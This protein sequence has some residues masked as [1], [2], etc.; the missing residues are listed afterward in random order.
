MLKKITKQQWVLISGDVIIA[1]IIT[2]W[3]FASH[4][5]LDTAGLYMLTTF[6]PVLVAW[7]MIAPLLGVYDLDRMKNIRQFW[8]PFYAM[9]IVSPMAALIRAFWLGRGIAPLFVVV[10]GGFSAL[11]ILLWRV[12]HWMLFWRGKL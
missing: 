2:L 12:V 7:L 1:V 8:R 11:G 10:L 6:I 9:I 5:T 4:D 3:G